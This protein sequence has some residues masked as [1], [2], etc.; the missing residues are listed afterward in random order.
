MCTHIHSHF[1]PSFSLPLSFS[2]SSL[3]FSLFR[4]WML[5]RYSISSLQLSTSTR[6]AR[7]RAKNRK[8]EKKNGRIYKVIG[9][10]RRIYIKTLFILLVLSIC[11]R[12]LRS[13]EKTRETTERKK[14]KREKKREIEREKIEMNTYTFNPQYAYISIDIYIH[15]WWEIS[16]KIYLISHDYV[17]FY[18][19][20][21]YLSNRK[22]ICIFYYW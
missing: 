2:L 10:G 19:H 13:R 8:R 22:E 7:A 4:R 12:S 1:L 16:S 9:Q 6:N 14:K 21:L 20:Q 17:K 11:V 18:D 5:R 15:T 3:F